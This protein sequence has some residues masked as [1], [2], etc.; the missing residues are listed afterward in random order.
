MAVECVLRVAG[1]CGGLDASARENPAGYFYGVARNVLHEWW[2]HELR[3]SR[4]RDAGRA[5]APGHGPAGME[6]EG[7][8]TA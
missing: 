7:R 4:K 2:R 3:D 1:K 8:C 6:P 5:R